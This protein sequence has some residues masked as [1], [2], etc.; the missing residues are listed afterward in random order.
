MSSTQGS[1]LRA[2][3]LDQTHPLSP[4]L[5]SNAPVSD[6]YFARSTSSPAPE[7]AVTPPEPATIGR[8]RPELESHATLRSGTLKASS[9]PIKASIQLAED[10]PLRAAPASSAPEQISNG[11][12]VPWQLSLAREPHL[13]SL[14]ELESRLEMLSSDLNDAIQAR[15]S[16]KLS[17]RAA[18]G[19][20]SS[21]HSS[22]S[23]MAPTAEASS[24]RVIA[25]SCAAAIL[26]AMSHEMSR[27]LEQKAEVKAQL[28]ALQALSDE[29][30]PLLGTSA[31]A[32]ER[33]RAERALLR[34]A[35]DGA[36][37]Y[38]QRPQDRWTLSSISLRSDGLTHDKTTS[39]DATLHEAMSDDGLRLDSD[40]VSTYSINAES[41][42]LAS[43]KAQTRASRH[44]SLSA[45]LFGGVRTPIVPASAPSSGLKSTTSNAVVEDASDLQPRSRANSISSGT[46]PPV[47]IATSASTPSK[48]MADGSRP[49]S[50]SSAWSWR[51]W[52]GTRSDEVPNVYDDDSSDDEEQSEVG[53]P[54]SDPVA[55]TLSPEVERSSAMSR[56][57]SRSGNEEARVA[58]AA[59]DALLSRKPNDALSATTP[60][61]ATAQ[62]I[63]SGSA[64]SVD[65]RAGTNGR[66]NSPRTLSDAAS[67]NGEDSVEAFAISSVSESHVS[68]QPTSIR[69][70]AISEPKGIVSSA[71]TTLS[72]ALGRS[73]SRASGAPVEP[74][75][76]LPTIGRSNSV[77]NLATP[78]VSTATA[79]VSSSGLAMELGT[80]APDGAVPPASSSIASSLPKADGDRLIDRYGFSHDQ[81][82]GLKYL[83][84]LRKRQKDGSK[85]ASVIMDV[86]AT[87]TGG[88]S[89]KR[90]LAQLGQM[91]EAREKAQQEVWDKFIVRRRAKLVKAS[92]EASTAPARPS[93]TVIA[94]VSSLATQASGSDELDWTE[95]LVG[96]ARMGSKAGREDWKEFKKLVRSG[97]PNALRPKIWAECSGSTEIRE[98]GYYTE[99]LS[100]HEGIH[101]QCLSQIDMDCHRTLPTNVFFG[102]NGPGISK[103]RRLL[104][105]YSWRNPE[106]G[107][108][109][110]MNMLAA[111]LL[112]IYTSEE[113]AFWIF[114]CIIERIL[115][116]EWYTSSLLV[117]QADQ[118]VLQDLVKTVLPK[119]SAHFDELGVTLPAVSFGWFL[120]LFTD[121]L[122]IQ[123]LL[124]VWD[125]F[126]VTGDVALFRITIAILQMHE[127]ELL[128]VADAASFYMTLRS[129]TTHM[130]QVDKLLRVAYE[131]LRYTV[132]SKDIAALRQKHVDELEQET[133]LKQT[134]V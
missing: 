36:A 68:S 33:S 30:L 132:K 93:R 43:P 21:E 99:M 125:C 86:P 134:G 92:S 18:R 129:I 77:F 56:A 131:D 5:P 105:A 123:T 104:V 32:R 72:R 9:T 71:A 10:S 124:R 91:T 111:V 12:R 90:L 61:V 34:A 28:A 70:L 19:S 39:L 118:R 74:N 98:P 22:E 116:G 114:C 110:G 25:A 38:Q 120:S 108:C 46:G 31:A 47:K 4:L 53:A 48:P 13:L 112:L 3:E 117:S 121:S 75:I 37:S 2:V 11:A 113:D 50:K 101:S 94:E 122:P 69:S 54:V 41:E 58:S 73:N 80:I 20:F 130:Y 26:Q 119:L 6:D 55:R 42:H 23:S 133:G 35:A 89:T 52:R 49:K 60:A 97:V 96:V 76:T 59:V 79:A 7:A 109:Q 84:E 126:F 16:S 67:A 24:S 107:Y 100:S 15:S 64:L 29:W 17:R 128:A 45:R 88:E 57:S 103:L 1:T 65:D 106:V 115:P 95:D 63:Q 83:Q 127:G 85:D 66:A 40:S 8:S 102:G 51:H 27:I 82:S 62:R 78:S 81:A 87:A 14:A 44:S